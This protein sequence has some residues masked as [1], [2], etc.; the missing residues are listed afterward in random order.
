M[1]GFSG[2]LEEAFAAVT[3]DSVEETTDSPGGEG[4]LGG[5]GELEGRLSLFICN[6][7]ISSEKLMIITG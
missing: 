5:G 6:I 2:E 4:L 3:R 7:L 1:D